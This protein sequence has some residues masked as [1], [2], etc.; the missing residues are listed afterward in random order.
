MAGAHSH[1]QLTDPLSRMAELDAFHLVQSSAVLG[2]QPVGIGET[3][4]RRPQRLA[5]RRQDVGRTITDP[6][7]GPDAYAG[8]A[9][10]VAHAHL[11]VTDAAFDSTASHLL[12]ALEHRS[13]RPELVDSVLDRVAPLRSSAVARH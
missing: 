9:L 1:L 4:V 13:V 2:E 6:G 10:D 11:G 12:D 5:D 7:H 3:G 8:R